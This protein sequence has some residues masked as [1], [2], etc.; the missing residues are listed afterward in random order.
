MNTGFQLS[1]ALCG[2]NLQRT[3]SL[4]R[5]CVLLLVAIVCVLEGNVNVL[6]YLLELKA[7]DTGYFVS[8]FNI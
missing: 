6:K 5:I 4:Q 2:T 3:D 1:P 7:L 8:A